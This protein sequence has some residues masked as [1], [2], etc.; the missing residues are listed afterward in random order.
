MTWIFNFLNFVKFKLLTSSYNYLLPHGSVCK[1][2]FWFSN[3]W[4]ISHFHLITFLITASKNTLHKM[5]F[6]IE[7]SFSKFDQIHSFLRI[8]SHLMKK[9]LTE[10]FI[11]C[12]VTP[13]PCNFIKKETLA[14][15]FS[16]EFVK[17]L[18]TPFLPEHLSC[19]L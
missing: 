12:A 3:F 14:Q 17:F 9:S 6:S 16:C 18:R 2:S 13:E 1:N 19:P 10:N 7:D 15:V 8:W 11:F 5:K 4:R